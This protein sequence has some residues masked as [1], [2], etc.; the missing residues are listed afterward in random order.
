LSLTRPVWQQVSTDSLKFHP[1]PPSPTLLYPVGGPP[2]KR[3]GSPAGW[4]ACGRLLPPWIPY[5]DGPVPHGH[6]SPPGSVSGLIAAGAGILLVL[7]V[8]I[9]LLRKRKAPRQPLNTGFVEVDSKGRD[10]M[11]QTE[12]LPKKQ[13]QT[14]KTNR[15]TVCLFVRPMSQ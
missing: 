1:G 13:T 14:Q 10:A 15:R 3:G 6:F 11:S 4:P 12:S 7:I 9:V 8:A 5:A 2:P